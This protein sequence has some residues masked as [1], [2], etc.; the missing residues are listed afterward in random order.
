MIVMK[1]GGTSV[2]DANA[3]NRAAAIVKGRQT[4][5]P[6]VVVSAMARI[7]DQLLSMARA[8]GAGDRKT[9]LKLSR[10]LRERHYETAGE[11][12]GTALFTQFHGELGSDFDAL[13]EL[14][15]GIAAVG[16]LTPR[17]TD[18]VAS[19]GEVLSSKIVA[20]AFS[21]RGLES[22]LVDSRECI[23]TDANYMRAAPLFEETNEQL[24]AVIQP[25]LDKGRVPVMGGFI[26]ANK[27]GVTTTIG[28]GGSD[29]SAAIVGAGLNAER[30]EIWTDVD[31][32]L[33]TDP[34]ICP[35]ARRI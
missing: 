16:E 32:M 26:G 30:I 11:L 20:A 10:A 5:R 7:T 31:G 8:A 2:E 28:R 4:E 23:V 22:S 25:L 21:A 15:R 18:Q 34:R 33:T 9:A 35:D 24:K 12:L 27:A 13:D 14:I 6:V 1:F 3:I 17:T 29:F 19:F